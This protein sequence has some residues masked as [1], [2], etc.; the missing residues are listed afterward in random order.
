MVDLVLFF[1][2]IFFSIYSRPFDQPFFVLLNIAVGGSWWVD[3]VIMIGEK[4]D[5]VFF[6]FMFRG[7]AQGLDENIF[8][9]RMEIDWVYYYQW[10]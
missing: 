10:R 5:N 4:K 8:P 2:E 1:K 3:F 6:L 9:R 7:G